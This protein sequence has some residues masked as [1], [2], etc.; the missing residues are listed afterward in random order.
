M[1]SLGLVVRAWSTLACVLAFTAT[2]QAASNGQ[3]V[4]VDGAGPADALITLN[5]IIRDDLARGD[6]RIYTAPADHR[7]DAPQWSPDG[8]RI[9]FAESTAE[10]SRIRYLRRKRRS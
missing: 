1:P 6:R 8:N 4:A 10:G 2:A 7:I 3:W 9:V 5:T